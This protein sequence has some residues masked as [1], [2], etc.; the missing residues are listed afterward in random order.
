M[1]E[2][3]SCVT[4]IVSLLLFVSISEA[5]PQL[6][7]G[8]P[9]PELMLRQ[10][11][12]A[13]NGTRGTW[14]ELKGKAVVLEF[15]A[16]WCGGCVDSIQHLNNLADKFK[17]RPVQ[18]ISITDE[19][20]FDVVHRFLLD[21]PISGWI[22]FDSEESTFERFGIGGRPATVLVSP[23]G[24]VRAIT[25]P[26]SVTPQVLVDLLA[27]KS[28]NFPEVP[29]EPLP[30][31]GLEPQAPPP[32]VQV[33]IRPAAPVEVSHMSPGGVTDK[34]GRYDAY[35][36]TL[37]GILSE[38]Y[39]IPENR[40]D[41]PEWC[42]RTRYD[43]SVVLPQ[44]DETLRWAMIKQV[45]AAAF[46]L[47]VHEEEKE[48]RVFILRKTD[49]QS[50]LQP[51]TTQGKSSSWNHRTGEYEG[52]GVSMK[53]LAN[54]AHFALDDEVLDETGLT[55]RY[56][57]KLKWDPRQPASIASAIRDQLGLALIPE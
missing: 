14:S 51:A 44:D 42:G 52:I 55:E 5:D 13:P 1:K 26:P 47:K 17:S 41:A 18:F 12:Q 46:G 33:L 25:N 19:T 8:T 27:D 30:S 28:L 57:F 40:V 36:Y 34:D 16:T 3:T 4:L 24:V 10:V 39:G 22:A 37:R 6:K 48:T 11:W 53:S 43:F 45:L 21:H 38:A 50:K 31:L 23:N 20:D 7:I 49:A 9:P 32:L 29:T 35:G 15:W 56:D 2:G 54:L